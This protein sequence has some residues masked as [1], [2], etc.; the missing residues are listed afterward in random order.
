MKIRLFLLLFIIICTQQFRAQ[1]YAASNFSLLSLIS[2]ETGT[3]TYGDKY[4]ACWGWTQPGTNREFAIACSKS[5]TY[6]VDV[7]NPV[8]P[9]ISAFAAGTTS[10]GVWRETKTYQNYCY[11][12]CDDNNSTGFQIFDMSALPSTVTLVSSNNSLFK[13]GHTLWVDGNKLYVAGITYSNGTTSSMNVYSLATPT[14][15]VLLR[16]LNQDYNFISYVHDMYVRNDTV[17]ASCGNQGLFV[18][19]FNTGINTFTQLGSLTSYTASGYNHSSALT[20]NG[21]YLVFTDEVPAGLPIKTANVSNLGNIQVLTTVNQFPQTTPHNPFIVGSQWCFV[22]AYQD[23]TQLWDISNPANPTLAGFFDTFP[24]GGG[25]NNNWAG[26]NY[27]GQWGMYPYFP[28]RNIF[29][30]DQKNGIFMLR[31]NLFQNPQAGFT[32]PSLVCG[33]QSVNIVNTS[34]AC[35]TYSWTFP[36][37]NPA[38][39]TATNPTV[40]FNNPGVYTVTV[41]GT[42]NQGTSV[43]TATINVAGISSNINYNNASC[44]MCADGNATVTVTGNYSPYTYTWMPSGGNAAAAGSL[45]P[46]CYTVNIE[47]TL[48]CIFSNSVCITFNTSIKTNNNSPQL[49]LYPDPAKDRLN[50]ICKG[51]ISCAEMKLSIYDVQGRLVLE[52]EN[53]PDNGIDISGLSGG[54]YYLKLYSDRSVI[55]KKF[56]ISE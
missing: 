18:F 23:G 19:K 31:S 52:K 30:L 4:S 9:S 50:L 2:P 10:N 38:T 3:N 36:G 26:D 49:T 54:I 39:S 14:A 44:G 40:I 8:S 13:R 48:G 25:N 12:V 1:V 46:G 22:S 24:Q 32:T 51:M 33:G 16:R 20:P 56:I 47:N 35:D 55:S 41:I 42:N 21:Q 43:A 28:S 5:G 37:G 6:W 29:A 7:T 45:A 53:V 27:D 15:P 34:T 11:V 17:Y